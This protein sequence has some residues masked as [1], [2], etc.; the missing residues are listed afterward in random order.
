M[1]DRLVT[2]EELDKALDYLARSATPIGDARKRL[3]MANHMVKHIKAL[4]MQKH[5]DMPVSAQE[6]EAVASKAYK[7][8]CLEEAVAAGEFEKLKALREA[9]AMRVEAWRTEQ[10]TLRAM[11]I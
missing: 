2:D 4:E 10:S 5:N 7:E 6:R 3:I 11:K 8:A 1:T 9:A